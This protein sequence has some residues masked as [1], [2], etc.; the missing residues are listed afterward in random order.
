MIYHICCYLYTGLFEFGLYLY[1]A[2]MQLNTQ[3]NDLN[4]EVLTREH[5][6]RSDCPLVKASC[7]DRFNMNEISREALFLLYALSLIFS[8]C[9]NLIYLVKNNSVLKV[10]ASKVNENGS[11]KKRAAGLNKTI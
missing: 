10:C 4:S 3:H 2:I 8:F 11:T 5:L 9:F 7:T 6:N 1:S